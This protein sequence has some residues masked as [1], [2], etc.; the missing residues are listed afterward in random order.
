MLPSP[1]ERISR[2]MTTALARVRF[3]GRLGSVLING[4]KGHK[5]GRGLSRWLREI[6]ILKFS[7]GI[8]SMNLS[9]W[10]PA[11]VC[12]R[13]DIYPILTGDRCIA[14]LS[15]EGFRYGPFHLRASLTLDDAIFLELADMPVQNLPIFCLRLLAVQIAFEANDLGACHTLMWLDSRNCAP[16]SLKVRNHRIEWLQMPQNIATCFIPFFSLVAG[17]FGLFHPN[18]TNQWRRSLWKSYIQFVQSFKGLFSPCAALF[19]SFLP[20]KSKLVQQSSID[21][22]KIADPVSQLLKSHRSNNFKEAYSTKV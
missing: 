16:G 9:K 18:V 1:V 22:L 21:T 13:E 2:P 20:F 17:G 5:S 12:L 3:E 4:V 14:Q 7:R 10:F 15:R 8:V 6:F 11:R 19:L